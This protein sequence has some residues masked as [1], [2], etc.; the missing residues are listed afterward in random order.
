MG[1]TA[2]TP[3]IDVLEPERAQ[4]GDVLICAGHANAPI[5]GPRVVPIATSLEIGRGGAHDGIPRLKTE[6]PLMSRT[7]AVIRRVEGRNASLR[8]LGSRN[9]TFVDGQ[10]LSDERPLHDGAVLFLGAHVFVYRRLSSVDLSAIEADGARPLGP[11]PTIS[12]AMARLS[13]RLKKLA[14]WDIDLLL[15]G[16]S[17]VGKEILAQAIH[18]E[19]QRSGPFVAINCAAIPETL[20]ESELFGYVRGAHSMAEQNK[21]GLIE[22][23]ENGTLFLDELGEMPSASQAKL[24]RF[25][26]DRQLLSLGTTRPRRLNVRVLAATHRSTNSDDAR[27]GLRLDLAARLGPEALVVPPLRDRPE[28]IGLLVS[29]FLGGRPRAFNIPAYR[30]LFLRK[31]PGNVRELEKTLKM[32]EILSENR[33]AIEVGDLSADPDAATAEDVRFEQPALA[34]RPTSMELGVLLERHHG[35][36]GRI[37]RE[38]GRQ[39]TLVWRWL[40]KAGLNP[41]IYRQSDEHE[42]PTRPLPPDLLGGHN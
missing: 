40:R 13:C 2:N 17:G 30:A 33:E 5:E 36:V 21:P 23:A 29:Y 42:P 4:L 38:I 24:L 12:A 34:E 20:I 28:D 1:E 14:R 15:A 26:Q 35:N 41:A 18:R 31:W 19:S 9:G 10:L 22:R 11:V 3:M 25:L 16:E 27:Q 8:D 32:A 6:D 7:H 37:A 39:R